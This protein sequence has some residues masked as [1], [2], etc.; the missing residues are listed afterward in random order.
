LTLDL[1]GLVDC[2]NSCFSHNMHPAVLLNIS[3]V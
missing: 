2:G 3:A 1:V